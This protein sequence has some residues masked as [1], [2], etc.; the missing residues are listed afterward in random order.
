MIKEFRTFS[1]HI[2]LC[3]KCTILNGFNTHPPNRQSSFSWFLCWSV[4]FHNFPCSI[5]NLQLLPPN[6]HS[7]WN[8]KNL[9][10][11]TCSLWSVY[12]RNPNKMIAYMQ[13]LAAKSQWTNF[14]VA[15]WCIPLATSIA[16]ANKFA[17]DKHCKLCG[18]CV[19]KSKQTKL[20][21]NK[22]YL[23]LQ[24]T[25]FTVIFHIFLQISIYHQ[26]QQNTRFFFVN[27]YSI[28]GQNI[29]MIKLPHDRS[30]LQKIFNCLIICFYFF[31]FF[32]KVS[33]QLM[34]CGPLVFNSPNIFVL[35]WNRTKEIQNNFFW[36][37]IYLSP[38][39]K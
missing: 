7:A 21:R 25:Y 3:C 17:E 13:F 37:L 2:T 19:S 22:K 8:P 12:S 23:F 32:V 16:K 9:H 10:H 26:R 39:A 24:D 35:T 38:Q 6:L 15:R 28:N 5:Q 31:S 30:F 34:L 11:C 4:P 29:W 33:F 1:Y 18:Y 27:R 36:F 14:L 20:Q